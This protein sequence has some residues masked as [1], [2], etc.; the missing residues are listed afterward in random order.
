MIHAP[1]GQPLRIE[2]LVRAEPSANVN[3]YKSGNTKVLPNSGIIVDRKNSS[4]SLSF[5]SIS[6]SDYDEYACVANNSLGSN[7]LKISVTGKPSIPQI[8][9]PPLAGRRHSY[10]LELSLDSESPITQYVIQWKRSQQENWQ[11][12]K[13]GREEGTW[14]ETGITKWLEVE[15][16][17]L[18]LD[19]NYDVIVWAENKYGSTQSSVF[20]FVTSIGVRHAQS[21]AVVV[22]LLVALCCK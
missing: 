11:S 5:Q 1:I 8:S 12:M 2:C 13:V 21:M 18:D 4:A 7:Q 10:R 6:E 9:S 15:V 14:S 3:W 17:N 20:S 16:E 22:A 19:E